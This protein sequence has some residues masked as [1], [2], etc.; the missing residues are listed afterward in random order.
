MN[1]DQDIS[2]CVKINLPPTRVRYRKVL[3]KYLQH[4]CRA[5][6]NTRSMIY[7]IRLRRDI[8]FLQQMVRDKW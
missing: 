8:V 6:L 3:P 2:T 4:M 1:E 5:P 7:K